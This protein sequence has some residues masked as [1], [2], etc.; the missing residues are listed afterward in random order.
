M[1]NKT[2]RELYEENNQLKRYLSF[3]VG[4]DVEDLNLKEIS[5]VSNSEKKKVMLVRKIAILSI[6]TVLCLTC[7]VFGLC[8]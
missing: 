6:V 5:K 7:F 4:C 2:K 3:W 8:W 1:A